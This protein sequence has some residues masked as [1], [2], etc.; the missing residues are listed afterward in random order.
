MGL[1][2]YAYV[3]TKAGVRD[4]YWAGVE[5]NPETGKYFNPTVNEPMEIAYWR[6]HPS[7]HGAM[8]QLWIKKGRPGINPGEEPSFNCIELELTWDDLNELEQLVQTN[9]LPYTT[10]FYFGNPADEEYKEHDLE[11]IKNA[12]AEIFLGLRV[13]YNSSW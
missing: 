5:I 7:W 11:F 6:K 4:D 3:A 9:Q 10:G 13:F 12:K 8:E 2:Q 1:D